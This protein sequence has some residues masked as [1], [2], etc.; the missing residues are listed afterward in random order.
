M[1]LATPVKRLKTKR[2]MMQTILKWQ[3]ELLYSLLR[4]RAPGIR[5]RSLQ[6]AVFLLYG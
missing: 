5:A 1:S 2:S 3:L 6:Q 4:L